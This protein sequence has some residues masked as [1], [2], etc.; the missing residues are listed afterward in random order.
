MSVRY[1]VMRLTNH[2]LQLFP[3]AVGS[4]SGKVEMAS[5]QNVAPAHADA[6]IPLAQAVAGV[7]E[8]VTISR[9]HDWA[10]TRCLSSVFGRLRG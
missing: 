8:T 4:V 3:I 2:L 1:A 5:D 7:G 9:K 10:R 6:E